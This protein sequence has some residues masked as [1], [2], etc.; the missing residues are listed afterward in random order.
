MLIETEAVKAGLDDLIE[1]RFNDQGAT[2][3]VRQFDTAMV[4]LQA[5]TFGKL[6]AGLIAVFRITENAVTDGLHMSAKLVGATGMRAQRH[7][8]DAR[9]GA[10]DCDIFG[11]GLFG[12][13]FVRLSRLDDFA[14]VE[15]LLD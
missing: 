6:R 5:Q 10:G 8:G 2:G 1:R 13:D 7:P 15:A 14:V 9:T 3:R 4:Q 12:A 11:F